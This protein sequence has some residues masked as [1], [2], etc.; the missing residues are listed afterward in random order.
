MLQRAISGD[1]PPPTRECRHRPALL[2]PLAPQGKEHVRNL[3]RIHELENRLKG[4][5]Y[6]SSSVID[7]EKYAQEVARSVKDKLRSAEREIT[8]QK[9]KQHNTQTAIDTQQAPPTHNPPPRPPHHARTSKPC[10]N[11]ADG[12]QGVFA[13]FELSRQLPALSALVAVTHVQP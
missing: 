5:N 9:F 2:L 8:A 12:T 11:S 4:V 3:K 13:T 6:K 10:S 1:K 7:S